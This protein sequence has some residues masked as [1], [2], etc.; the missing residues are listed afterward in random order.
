MEVDSSLGEDTVLAEDHDVVGQ[1]DVEFT[2]HSH[3]MERV[4]DGVQVTHE[5]AQATKVRSRCLFDLSF[6][7]SFSR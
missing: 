6:F 5:G 1:E 3:S 2:T 4:D 7:Q